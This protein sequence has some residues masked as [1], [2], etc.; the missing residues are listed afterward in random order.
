MINLIQNKIKLSNTTNNKKNSLLLE[1]Y[2]II[3]GYLVAQSEMFYLNYVND[4]KLLG[5]ENKIKKLL[6]TNYNILNNTYSRNDSF[7]IFLHI[8]EKDIDK[9]THNKLIRNYN[10]GYKYFIK[11]FNNESTI[12]YM[13][14]YHK[15][16]DSKIRSLI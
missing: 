12:P 4:Y 2:T 15:I 11:N 6:N 14:G 3:L 5:L 1:S 9:I 10:Y 8:I 13:F 16:L 7:K